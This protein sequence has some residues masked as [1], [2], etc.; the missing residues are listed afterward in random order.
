MDVFTPGSHGST[1]GGNPFACAIARE[2]LAIIREEKPEERSRELGDWFGAE[3]RAMNSKYVGEIRQRGLFVG[4]DIKPEF[5][6][7]K[8][9]CKKLMKHGVLSKDTRDQTIRFAP[10]LVIAKQDLEWGLSEIRAVFT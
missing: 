9:F 8:E 6:K 2:V 1:F 5:G 4:M 7:A 3:L 10:P